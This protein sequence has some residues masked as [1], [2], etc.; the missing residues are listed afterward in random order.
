MMERF[1]W[2]GWNLDLALSASSNAAL[3][4]RIGLATGHLG[5]AGSSA[6]TGERTPRFHGE[7]PCQ[8][9]ASLGITGFY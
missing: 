8:R 4:L 1:D 6:L 3:R 9:R 7:T 2:A 5:E